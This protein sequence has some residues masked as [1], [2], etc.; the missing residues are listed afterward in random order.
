MPVLSFAEGPEPGPLEVLAQQLLSRGPPLIN[1]ILHLIIPEESFGDFMDLVREYLPDHQAD[2]L[3]GNDVSD[4]L[5]LFAHYFRDPYFPL[6]YLEDAFANEDYSY[7]DLVSGVPVFSAGL[8]WDDYHELANQNSLARRLLHC[9]IASPWGG[10]DGGAKLTL[11]ESCLAEIPR[12]LLERIPMEGY[13]PQDLHLFFDDSEYSALALLADV[14]FHQ[15]GS[16]F[17]DADQ[18]D[19]LVFDWSMETVLMLTEEWRMTDRI[20]TALNELQERLDVAAESRYRQLLDFLDERK[21]ELNWSPNQQPSPSPGED[22]PLID[23]FAP[24]T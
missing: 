21:A 5:T 17:I 20:F 15:T 9:L 1:A 13:S 7:G 16:T 24:E 10:M 22:T 18:E 4:H 2:I 14:V 6:P 12:E 8:D 23:V 11:M 19:Y 3:T